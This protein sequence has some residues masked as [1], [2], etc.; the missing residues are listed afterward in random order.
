MTVPLERRAHSSA[1]LEM[2]DLDDGAVALRG[3]AAVFDT[4]AHQEVVRRSAFTRALDD[5]HD[6]RLLV[7]HDGVPLARTTSGTLTLTVDDRGLIADATL[8]PANPT[9]AE[10][11]SA[12]ARGDIDQ[13]SFAFR[14][15]RDD[16]VDGVRE[17]VEVELWDVSV[18]TYPWYEETHAELYSQL[19]RL[20][21]ARGADAV[22]T[23]LAAEPAPAAPEPAAVPY[24][25]LEAARALFPHPP[26]LVTP[27]P[28]APDP[29]Q[30]T[31]R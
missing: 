12:M 13:M 28:T 3:Y 10:L 27:D 6:V 4:P 18:V 25:R 11:R 8:D 26:D 9:V 30:G 29:T 24:A 20:V 5:G 16:V 19:D 31:T 23:L 15:V 2:R 7:N 17:L 14:T 22:A 21:E 1:D